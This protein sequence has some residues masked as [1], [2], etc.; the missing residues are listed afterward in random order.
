MM[1]NEKSKNKETL[2]KRAYNEKNYD[3][4]TIFVNKGDKDIVKR[5]AAKRNM[6]MNEYVKKAIYTM[7]EQEDKQRSCYK[8]ETITEERIK[9]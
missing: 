3:I 5:R 4:I 7:M 2:S 8:P 9:I 6:S 1:S